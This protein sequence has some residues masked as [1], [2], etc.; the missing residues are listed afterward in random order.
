MLITLDIPAL[1]DASEWGKLLSRYYNE[2]GCSSS[3]ALALTSVGLYLSFE[4]FELPWPEE[5]HWPTLIGLFIGAAA[6]GKIGGLAWGQVRL[7]NT[8]K[9]LEKLLS[10]NKNISSKNGDCPIRS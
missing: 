1:S 7:K 2:C 9:K 4:Y 8:I 5:L 10:A 6:V 3:A